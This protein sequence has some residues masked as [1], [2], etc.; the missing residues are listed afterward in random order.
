MRDLSRVLTAT[1]LPSKRLQWLSVPCRISRQRARKDSH[2]GG[3]FRHRHGRSRQQEFVCPGL[4]D[5][6]VLIVIRLD[7][8][9]FNLKPR[10]QT[11]AARVG[12]DAGPQQRVGRSG[13]RA[14]DWT[15]DRTAFAADLK[16]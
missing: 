15:S 7:D 10:E 9:A 13:S 5:R 6:H 16:F 4:I 2:A 1:S 8:Y 14:P 12:N 11:L 3:H